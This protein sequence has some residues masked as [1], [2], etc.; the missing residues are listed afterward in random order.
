MSTVTT[1]VGC[2]FKHLALLDLE[3]NQLRSIMK[4]KWPFHYSPISG[5][6]RDSYDSNDMTARK[7]Q[8]K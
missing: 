6:K 1:L 7:G 4:H 5:L 3:H 8:P 2:T